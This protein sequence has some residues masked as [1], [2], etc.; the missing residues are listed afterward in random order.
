MPSPKSIPLFLLE[1]IKNA[2]FTAFLVHNLKIQVAVY[3][4]LLQFIWHSSEQ[5]QNKLHFD[6]TMNKIGTAAIK[7]LEGLDYPMPYH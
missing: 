1:R 2:N 4:E 6:G 7:L 3:R 5:P